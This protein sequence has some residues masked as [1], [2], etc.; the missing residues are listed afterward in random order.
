MSKHTPGP[1]TATSLYGDDNPG[2][3][4][5]VWADGR[6]VAIAQVFRRSERSNPFEE[7]RANTHLMAAAPD[8]LTA[9]TTI[10]DKG[11][12]GGVEAAARIAGDA[13]EKAGVA[14]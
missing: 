7:Q 13:I 11:Y 8:L 5:I 6:N 10:R 12:T 1:W 4:F 2:R 9:L 14:S 3:E